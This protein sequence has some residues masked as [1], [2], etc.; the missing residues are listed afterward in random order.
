MEKRLSF[1]AQMN[2]KAAV[3]TDTL[4]SDA[5][6]LPGNSRQL[7]TTGIAWIPTIATLVLLLVVWSNNQVY[8]GETHP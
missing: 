4:G 7:Y 3:Y 6:I 8:Q 1:P 2:T 5:A